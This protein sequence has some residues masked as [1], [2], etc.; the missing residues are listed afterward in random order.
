MRVAILGM[1]AIGHVVAKALDGRVDLVRVDRTRS[2]LRDREAP[3]DAAVV[4]TKTF[5]TPWAADVA[6]RVIARDGVV[7]TVQNGLGNFETLAA[8]VGADRVSLGA[9]Y[10]GARLLP[11]GSLFST[12][13]GRV[14]LGRPRHPGA[15]ERLDRLAEQL[16]DGGMQVT[17]VDDPWP[18]DWRKLSANAA[19]N[20]TTAI[21][22]LTNGEVLGHPAAEALADELARETARVATAAGVR[23]PEEEA[24]AAWRDIAKRLGANRSSMLQDVD[25]GK[26]TEIDAINGAV[27]R[28][29][30][31]V[32]VPAPV[33][34]AITILM[35]AVSAP[36]PSVSSREAARGE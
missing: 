19:M 24:V 21:F 12:G 25:A 9:I 11:D 33:N 1:G 14:E 16:G 3:V 35:Q 27:A 26:P 31:R 29:G 30:R 22:R 6:A 13:A 23:F 20:P 2:P 15:R 18:S 5:G 36:A 28:E 8:K 34:E 17:V 7:A 32:G 10:V 4:C